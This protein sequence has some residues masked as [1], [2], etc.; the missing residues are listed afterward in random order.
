MP[1]PS[2]RPQPPR[3]KHS[4][5]LT[6][7]PLRPF[8][9]FLLA[10]L[11]NLAPLMVGVT[12]LLLWETG[13]TFTHTPPYLLPSPHVIVQ[14]LIQDRA[15]LFPALAV[16][17]KI[18][19]SAFS[20]AIASGVS[21]ATLFSVNKWIE[22]SLYPYAVILQT[23]PLAAIA[24]LI[25]LWLGD[26]TFGALVICAWIVALFPI[27]ANTTLGLTSIDPS[28]R[29]LFRLYHA[30]PW[31]TLRYLRLP[32]ALPYFL[33]GLRISGGLA[34]IG[35][36]V[37]EFVIG[38]TSAPPGLA[39]QILQASYTLQTPRMFA[40]LTLLTGVGVS[41]FIGLNL[42]SNRLLQPWHPSVT[43]RD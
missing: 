12:T 43:P 21:I 27:I 8:S 34:L 10:L 14:T 26:N 41:I 39:Y 16:T 6:M 36:V 11:P 29:N 42:L 1:N 28:L 15:I 24:P 40:A 23:T 5:N 7:Q 30:T 22:R 33:G 2:P 38:T 35:A 17:L 20:L 4:E 19:L 18:T 31:Q 25:V 13:I 32:S 37:A 3:P 9:P